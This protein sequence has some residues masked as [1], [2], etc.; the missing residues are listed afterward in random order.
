[1]KLVEL[2]LE[3]NDLPK[4]IEFYENLLP[5][6]KRTNWSDGSAAA[7]VLSDGSAIGL[8]KK[9]KR[10]LFNGR[11]GDHTHYA[12]QIKPDEYEI[13]LERIKKLQIEYNE[14]TWKNGHRSIYY[15]DPDNHQGEFITC[16]WLELFNL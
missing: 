13:Y 8:W 1:M 7:F 6:S 4:S 9:G 16:D 12:I 2:H 3:V 14:H 5:D 10:G 11:S 15:F